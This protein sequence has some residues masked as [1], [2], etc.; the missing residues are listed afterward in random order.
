MAMIKDNI[1]RIRGQIAVVCQRIGRNPD[2]VTLVVATKYADVEK[3]KEVIAAGVGD[4]GENR[5]QDGREK[6]L[7]LDA[8]PHVRRHM[9]GHLQ[10]N[11]VKH[12]VEM[13]DV[14]QSVDSV[15][16]AVEISKQAVK[17]NKTI[18]IF[19]EV[20][21]SGEEQKSGINSSEAV[22]LIQDISQFSN[23]HIRGLMTMAPLVDDKSIIR[24]CFAK[25]RDVRDQVNAKF[26]ESPNVKM[27]FLSM[28]M[29]EDFE[30]A[31]E[32]GSNMVRIGRAIFA[33]N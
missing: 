16:L 26:H 27:Q 3:I 31:L 11:K 20:K 33:E 19:I 29:S 9:I 17:L 4:I 24:S 1:A 12:A 22:K 32:E 5:V 30:I 2:E 21:T 28:G 23:L 15:K 7:K 6:F 8:I 25:L 13:F 10:T 18:D 14:I